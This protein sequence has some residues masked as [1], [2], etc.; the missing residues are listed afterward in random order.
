[1][2]VVLNLVLWKYISDCDCDYFTL[3]LHNV[4]NSEV[5]PTEHNRAECNA[6]VNHINVEF[7]SES[8]VS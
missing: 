8:F 7:N 4:C 3:L 5:S 6:Y 1:M 2:R